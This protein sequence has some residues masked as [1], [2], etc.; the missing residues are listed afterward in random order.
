[1]TTPSLSGTLPGGSP[2]TSSPVIQI[3][4]T[5]CHSTGIYPS[6]PYLDKL[7]IPSINSSLLSF[8]KL[9][10]YN[11][12]Q[13]ITR[14]ACKFQVLVVLTSKLFALIQNSFLTTF[15]FH[16]RSRPSPNSIET[17]SIFYPSWT[18]PCL[19]LCHDPR[20]GTSISNQFK[21]A[22]FYNRYLLLH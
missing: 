15:K 5:P 2:S 1:M 3:P 16:N 20:D 22:D 8:C 4:S 17:V 11:S 6:H 19:L 13:C 9:S 14:P 21:P 12:F 18:C 10:D 7:Y